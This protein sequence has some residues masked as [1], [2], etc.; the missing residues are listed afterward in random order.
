MDLI[1]DFESRLATWLTDFCKARGLDASL[2]PGATDVWHAIDVEPFLRSLELFPALGMGKF[3]WPRGHSQIGLFG[4]GSRASQPRPPTFARE[5][6]AV[7]G[8]VADLHQRLN[9]PPNLIEVETARGVFDFAAYAPVAVESE[10]MVIAGEAKQST[11]ELERWL[12][13]LLRCSE[14]GSHESQE[15]APGARMATRLN[16]HTKWAGLITARPDWLWLVAL[17]GRR[18]FRLTY[19]SDDKILVREGGS[20]P[21]V[22]YTPVQGEGITNL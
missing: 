14:I 16:A 3:R 17:G 6:I 12:P 13:E 21:G 11:R 19:V 10:R 18:A 7:M 4:H 2:F 9:W 15:H 5:T 1:S 22:D 20:T 8:A